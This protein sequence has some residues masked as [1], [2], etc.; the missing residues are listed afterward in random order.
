MPG[1]AAAPTS[2]AGSG[3]G[4]PDPSAVPP[5]PASPT[6]ASPAAEPVLH[7]C[8][9]SDLDSVRELAKSFGAGGHRLDAIVHNA[10]VMPDE[11]RRTAQGWELAYAT[12]LLGPFLLTQL[13]LPTLRDSDDGAVVFVSSG[14]MYTSRWR[15]DPDR[16]SGTD[17]DREYSGTKTSVS[18][19]HLTLPTIYSV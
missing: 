16:D 4:T 10:G 17:T 8:D 5:G 7:R 19:T 15:S 1:T 13:L 18:Y 12:N 3:P 6:A 9:I 14:G 2:D 11:R